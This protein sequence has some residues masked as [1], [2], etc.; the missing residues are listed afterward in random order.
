MLH[1]AKIVYF[2]FVMSDI[3]KPYKPKHQEPIMATTVTHRQ[4]KI[5]VLDAGET[6]AATCQPGDIAICAAADGWWTRFIGEDGSVDSYDIPY[7]SYNE[8]LWAAKA[9]AE[10]GL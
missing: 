3:S 10:Y 4:V 5:M 7:A 8:A 2:S 9:A 1:C 6:I